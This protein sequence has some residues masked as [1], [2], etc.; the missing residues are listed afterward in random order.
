MEET[1]PECCGL[2]NVLPTIRWNLAGLMTS[3]RK[4]SHCLLA[5]S[6]PPPVLVYQNKKIAGSIF[7]QL[8]S[9]ETFSVIKQATVSASRPIAWAIK[10]GTDGIL[11]PD[12]SLSS[13]R[14]LSGSRKHSFSV[15]GWL[16][17]RV[18]YFGPCFSEPPCNQLCTFFRGTLI[19]TL[20]KGW[21]KSMPSQKCEKKW[22]IFR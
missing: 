17:L 1:L 9:V 20:L 12:W 4:E 19:C 5:G 2:R 13:L 10:A 6:I 22:G 7:Q 11:L 18:N 15:S 14:F 3:Q 8:A 21:E 16:G